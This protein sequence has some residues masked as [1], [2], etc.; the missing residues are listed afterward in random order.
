MFF[1]VIF[2]Y[3]WIAYSEM[4]ARSCGPLFSCVPVLLNFSFAFPRSCTT[5]F[6][7][8]PAFLFLVP[9]VCVGVGEQL[10]TRALFVYGR[11]RRAGS[12]AT[13]LLPSPVTRARCTSILAGS[14]FGVKL[15]TCSQSPLPPLLSVHV[16]TVSSLQRNANLAFLL[17]RVPAILYKICIPACLRS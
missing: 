16:I 13:A 4:G 10:I 8:S 14:Q 17:F 7:R 15:V 9:S 1:E 5:F 3:M 6:S 2:V 11:I 12:I